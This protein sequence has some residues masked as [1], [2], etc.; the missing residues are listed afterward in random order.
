MNID[1]W[2]AERSKVRFVV[3]RVRL[4]YNRT[5]PVFTNPLKLYSIIFH[6][7]CPIP[8][9]EYSSLATK[10]PGT[11]ATSDSE[12]FMLQGEYAL[13]PTQGST[14]TSMARIAQ[15]NLKC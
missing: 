7:T 2:P 11:P 15:I 6:S 13:L 10:D 9:A 3:I 12:S 1:R 5:V 8:L 14:F 4:T